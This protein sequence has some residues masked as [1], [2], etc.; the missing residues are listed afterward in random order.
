M[1][2]NHHNHRSSALPAVRLAARWKVPH[3]Y[4]FRNHGYHKAHSIILTLAEQ[5]LLIPLFIPSPK[6]PRLQ[7]PSG[8]GSVRRCARRWR[9]TSGWASGRAAA[10]TPAALGS[11]GQRT[12][13]GCLA[14]HTKGR[15]DAQARGQGLPGGQTNQP[16]ERGLG[17]LAGRS[18]LEEHAGLRVR[19]PR[20]QLAVAGLLGKLLTGRWRRPGRS[21]SRPG[22]RRGRRGGVTGRRRGRRARGLRPACACR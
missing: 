14:G 10:R 2:P 21:A 19:R 8:S 22:R 7:A 15:D 5:A 4:Y 11:A 20:E 12:P 16:V 9:W 6:L 13:C 18:T 1:P 3:S 17:R